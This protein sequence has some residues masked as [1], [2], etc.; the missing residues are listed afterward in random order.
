[1]VLWMKAKA[2][3]PKAGMPREERAAMEKEEREV[4]EREERLLIPTMDSSTTI[5]VQLYWR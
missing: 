1:M 5:I 4:T 3:D 2:W